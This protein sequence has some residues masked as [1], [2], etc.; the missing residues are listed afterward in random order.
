MGLEDGVVRGLLCLCPSH[1]VLNMSPLV[2]HCVGTWCL[3]RGGCKSWSFKIKL[4]N[5]FFF[6]LKEMGKETVRGEKEKGEERE[7]ERG[8]GGREVKERRRKR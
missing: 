4:L 7:G 8:K 2:S 6:F 1:P 3:L 5:I